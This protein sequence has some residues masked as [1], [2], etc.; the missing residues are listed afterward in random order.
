MAVCLPKAGAGLGRLTLTA[1][2]PISEAYVFLN[3]SLT[4]CRT[5]EREEVEAGQEAMAERLDVQNE[6]IRCAPRKPGFSLDLAL[7]QP[8]PGWVL[9]RPDL[10]FPK[11]CLHAGS[12]SYHIQLFVT[13]GP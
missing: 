7:L 9:P 1:L 13:R 6:D 8:L 2:Q 11:W 10:T 5:E 4:A 12:Q 3:S